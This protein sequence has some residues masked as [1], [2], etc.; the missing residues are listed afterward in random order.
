MDEQ[1]FKKTY[2]TFGILRSL[3]QTVSALRSKENADGRVAG[4]LRD[5]CRDEGRI[6]RKLGRPLEGLRILEVGPGQRMERARYFA[7]MNT[8]TAIDL[9]IIPSGTNLMSY[10]RMLKKNSFGRVVK[11]VGRK[12]LLV[13]RSIR[14]AWVRALGNDYLPEP[15]VVHGDIC[16]VVP[17]PGG[18]D[19]VLSWSVFEHIPDPRKALENVIQA[20]QPGGI[21]YFGIHLYTSHNGHHDIRGFGGLNTGFPLWGHLR[22]STNHLIHSSAYLNKWR[23]SQWRGLFSEITPGFNEFLETYGNDKT[24]GKLMT[25]DLRCELSKYTDEELYTV[26]AYYMWKKPT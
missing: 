6:V 2:A 16:A 25:D 14:A 12:V 3:R 13:D 7:R 5:L 21:F 22:D 19:V 11:T 26:D 15:K 8:V 17:M 23:L 20:L 18:F 24:L 4:L 1:K 9:D 10:S